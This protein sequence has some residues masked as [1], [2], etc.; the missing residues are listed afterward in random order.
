M[1][2]AD[3]GICHRKFHDIAVHLG[4]NLHRSC[5]RKLD[6]I[7]H[8]IQHDLLHSVFVPI[9]EGSF[10]INGVDKHHRFFADK[11]LGQRQHHIGHDMHIHRMYREFHDIFF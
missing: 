10:R 8:Q 3:A 2:N 6:G 9:Y 7:A 5:L 11:G 4:R 1:G